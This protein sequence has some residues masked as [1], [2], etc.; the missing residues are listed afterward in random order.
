MNRGHV[1]GSEYFRDYCWLG[2]EFQGLEKQRDECLNALTIE[3]I[4]PFAKEL[5]KVGRK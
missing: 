2:M 4:C 3:S 1:P 5:M